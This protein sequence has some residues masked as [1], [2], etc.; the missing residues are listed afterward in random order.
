[1]ASNKYNFEKYIKKSKLKTLIVGG[2]KVA[3][4]S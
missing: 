2:N 3:S 1:M 4:Y